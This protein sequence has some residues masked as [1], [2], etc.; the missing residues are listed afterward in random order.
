MLIGWRAAR[1]RNHDSGLRPERGGFRLLR[2]LA[3]VLV[4]C[5]CLPSF[6][7]ADDATPVAGSIAVALLAGILLGLAAVLFVTL[8]RGAA[9]MRSAAELRDG[10]ELLLRMAT[11]RC[12]TGT[13]SRAS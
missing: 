2:G 4:L 12:S 6:A 10:T 3:A 7:R 9:M 5:C 1:L 8:R 11:P 13:S